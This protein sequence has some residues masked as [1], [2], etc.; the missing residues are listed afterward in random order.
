MEIIKRLGFFLSI[1][2]ST[3]YKANGIIEI[4]VTYEGQITSPVRDTPI[5]KK[6]EKDTLINDFFLIGLIDDK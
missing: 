1:I 3:P 6:E 2:L 5:A 4:E